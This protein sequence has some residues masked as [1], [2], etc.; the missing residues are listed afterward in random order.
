M[1]SRCQLLLEVRS[2]SVVIA[3]EAAAAAATAAT[4]AATRTTSLPSDTPVPIDR[5]WPSA[6]TT[7]PIPSSADMA[8]AC[9]ANEI[10]LPG[11]V[12]AE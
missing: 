12:V 5:A 10:P 11:Q 8:A 2:Q 1:L 3:R 9:V 6:A 7:R 4:E